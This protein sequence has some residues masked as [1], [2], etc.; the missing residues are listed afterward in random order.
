MKIVVCFNDSRLFPTDHRS[1]PEAG[2]ASTAFQTQLGPPRLSDGP[3]REAHHEPKR[4]RPV[5]LEDGPRGYK[6]SQK[7]GSA[8][9]EDRGLSEETV[10]VWKID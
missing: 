1:Q 4:R 7:T 10:T 9:R 5:D 2:E 8:G 6:A 3:I